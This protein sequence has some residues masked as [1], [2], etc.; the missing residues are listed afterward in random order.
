MNL[1]LYPPCKLLTN[2]DHTPSTRM[3][4]ILRQPAYI[5]EQFRTFHYMKLQ[6][7][8][9]HVLPMFVI[10]IIGYQNS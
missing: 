3:N 1:C 9:Y 6:S 5:A 2:L 7:V 10:D 4:Q 8:V